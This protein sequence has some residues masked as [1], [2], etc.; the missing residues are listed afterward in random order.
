MPQETTN[1]NLR[2][3]QMA[4]G[5]EIRRPSGEGDLKWTGAAEVGL[6]G[7]W[8]PS[9]MPSGC[10]EGLCWGLFGL[11]LFQFQALESASSHW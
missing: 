7:L 3:D 10:M 8:G 4:I 2:G 1:W 5:V 9:P 6:P 11:L